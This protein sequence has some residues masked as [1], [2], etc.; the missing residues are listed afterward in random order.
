PF[1]APVIPP[2][3]HRAEWTRSRYTPWPRALHDIT[4]SS[5]TARVLR[6]DHLPPRAWIFPTTAPP[7]PAFW[8][9]TLLT[10]RAVEALYAT[11]PW[12]YL[13]R[14]IQPLTFD[15]NDRHFQPFLARYDT[16]LDHWGQAYW[17]ATHELPVPHSPTW[18]RWRRRGNSRRSHAGDHLMC[19]FQLLVLLFQAGRADMDL[20][21]DVMMLLFP[22][23]RSSVGRWYPDLQNPTLEAALV[24]VAAREPWRRFFPYATRRRRQLHRDSRAPGVFRPPPSVQ[25][26]RSWTT[27][28][29]DLVVAVRLWQGVR[30]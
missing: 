30:S 17:E 26:H 5:F 25:V 28:A 1:F 15:V 9:P 11:R 22:P 14:R 18:A 2:F 27:L 6:A 8:D 10:E 20:L 29:I 21:L 12:D 23:G 4:L 13:A 19:A 16:H 3:Q 7:A 24:A